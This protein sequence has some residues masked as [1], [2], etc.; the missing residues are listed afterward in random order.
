MDFS[1]WLVP[2]GRNTGLYVRHL[3][4]LAKSTVLVNLYL[5]ITMGI[6]LQSAPA[7]SMIG[8]EP[9]LLYS[10]SRDSGAYAAS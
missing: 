4:T 10:R 3:A 6:I 8:R 2:Y 7:F 9:L 1:P 5:S